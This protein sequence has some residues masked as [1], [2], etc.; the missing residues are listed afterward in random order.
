MSEAVSQ[1]SLGADDGWSWGGGK[2]MTDAII[3]LGQIHPLMDTC[4]LV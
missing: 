2:K 1:E 3:K 4:L